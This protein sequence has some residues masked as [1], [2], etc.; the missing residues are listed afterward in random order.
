[1][2]QRILQVM[3]AVDGIDFSSSLARVQKLGDGQGPGPARPLRA[4]HD[5]RAER[6]EQAVA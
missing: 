6:G 4:A 5:L 1:M 2:R 3:N